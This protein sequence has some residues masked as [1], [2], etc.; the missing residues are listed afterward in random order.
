[1]EWFRF[2]SGR[3]RMSSI[4]Q[5]VA[6]TTCSLHGDQ[7]STVLK[8]TVSRTH[9]PMRFLIQ[10][11]GPTAIFSVVKGQPAPYPLERDIYSTY[12]ETFHFIRWQDSLH[13]CENYA[14]LEGAMSSTVSGTWKALHN[15]MLHEQMEYVNSQRHLNLGGLCQK[16]DGWQEFLAIL[17]T[18]ALQCSE[19]KTI[20]H[21]MPTQ[22]GRGHFRM[23]AQ[24]PAATENGFISNPSP[25]LTHC[26]SPTLK[27]TPVAGGAG[28]DGEG[29]CWE[30]QPLWWSWQWA[31][32]SAN[33]GLA[34]CLEA[35]WL[36]LLNPHDNPI[37]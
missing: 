17:P 12:K 10:N 7:G 21:A 3:V 30:R 8:T 33:P 34:L 1:M 28:T 15:G 2:K 25:R 31:S 5:Q 26:S 35:T 18:S 16:W 27:D 22:S 19:N 24:Y 11:V 6:A 14:L 37:E 29:T 20:S 32:L 13:L 9:T 36:I 4:R 23:S